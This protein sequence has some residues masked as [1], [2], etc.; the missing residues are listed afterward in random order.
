M[1]SGVSCVGHFEVEEAVAENQSADQ[2]GPVFAFNCPLVA[3]EVAAL[4][5]NWKK[6]SA[7]VADG[8]SQAGFRLAESRTWVGQLL[9]LAPAGPE[10]RGRSS[11]K[12]GGAL[13]PSG[14]RV[15]AAC[16]STGEWVLHRGCRLQ[17][18]LC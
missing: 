7:V 11:E 16:K 17:P 14:G 15:P 8:F 3:V 13:H 4:L 2:A 5:K 10:R 18:R 9:A 1:P 12:S 6:P